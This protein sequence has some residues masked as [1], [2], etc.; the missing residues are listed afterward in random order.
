MKNEI[1]NKLQ[2]L[3]E[4][5]P[6]QRF[7]QVLYNYITSAYVNNDTFYVEDK[8]ILDLLTSEVQEIREHTTIRQ[9]IELDKQIKALRS[10]K[11]D[12]LNNLTD[13]E[14]EQY[15]KYFTNEVM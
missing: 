3:M 1:I 9:M 2:E 12:I 15:K 7:G 13:K 6:E 14:K 5:V 8:N 4:L 11:Q 10:K